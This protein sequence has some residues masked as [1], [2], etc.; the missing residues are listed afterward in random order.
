TY[1]G[2]LAKITAERDAKA[3]PLLD[4]YLKT[5]DGYVAELTKAGKIEEA[6]QV[7]ALR[8]AKATPKLETEAKTA[9]P[10][11]VTPADGPATSKMSEREVAEWMLSTGA[12]ISVEGKSGIKDAASLPTGRI[13]ITTGSINSDKTTNAEL[14]RLSVCREMTTLSF[15]YQFPDQGV[16]NLEPIRK[17]TQLWTLKCDPPRD[18]VGMEI[19]TG[20]K[21]LTS[22]RLGKT[23]GKEMEKI[24]AIKGLKSLRFE[25]VS[26]PHFAAL[27]D[28]KNLRLLHVNGRP[29]NVRDADVVVLVAA[30]PDLEEL[31]LGENNNPAPITDAALDEL[32]K[33]KKLK[34]LY[35]KETKVS[36]AALEKLQKALPDCKLTK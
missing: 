16:I 19:I 30:L 2:A 32:A 24:T 22:L 18:D 17:L 23:E 7:Q 36:A 29:P 31:T 34:G 15:N 6:K 35:L 5:L 13:T 10:A 25:A 33:L 11:P 12:E 3:A 28:C 8:D 9:A 21:N 14:A 4:L 26:S 20:L 27:K 1:R